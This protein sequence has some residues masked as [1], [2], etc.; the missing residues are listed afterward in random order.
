MPGWIGGQVIGGRPPVTVTPGL[1]ALTLTGFAPTIAIALSAPVRP[2]TGALT[3]TGF[4]PTVVA[5]TSPMPVGVFGGGDVL[6]KGPGNDTSGVNWSAIQYPPSPSSIIADIATANADNVLLIM[7]TGGQKASW[8][9]ANGDFSMALFIDQISRFTTPAMSGANAATITAAF[10]SR[11]MV[12]YVVDEP[13]LNNEITPAQVNQ[14]CAEIKNIWPNSLTVVRST[15]TLLQ[16]WGG[17]GIPA[18]GYS[19]MDY[20]WAQWTNT[21]AKAGVTFAQLLD[22]ERDVIANH[23][24]N[25]GLFAGVNLWAGGLFTNIDGINACWDYNN[26]G[27]S[28]GYRIGD[29][30]SGTPN[31]I[32]CGGSLAGLKS[33]LVSP[34]WLLKCAQVAAAQPDI[35]AFCYWQHTTGNVSSE[36]DFLYLRPDY[37]A[38]FDQA[39]A[40]GA[41]RAAWIGWRTP[42]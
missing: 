23:N 20:A 14:M 30:D 41:V 24:M 9:D 35:A 10:A 22:G 2:G 28:S 29:R 7:Q 12:H 1:G 8:R 11:R 5:S 13:Y 31:P 25:C 4:A 17:N 3:L 33:L 36:Y 39:I 27:S 32:T 26:N 19:K 18:G 42:K 15:P 37:V 16:G 6:G 21:H 38:K 40:A 34:A